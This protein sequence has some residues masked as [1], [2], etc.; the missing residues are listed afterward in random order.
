L[1]WALGITQHSVGSS[2]TRILAI[3]QLV[4]GNIGKPG[5][6]TNI[7]RGHDNVQGA[8]DMGC[9]ADTLP[10]YYGLDDNAWNHFSNVWNVEREYLNLRFYSKEW[11]HEKG[12]SLAKWWQG[13]LHEEKTYS[14]SP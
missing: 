5:A 14:N 7:I 10:A 6:G 8:T 3:L 4:L 11:M 13:V 12:F 9:L 2:N 1:F